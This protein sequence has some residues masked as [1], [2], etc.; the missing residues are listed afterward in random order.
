MSSASLCSCNAARRFDSLSAPMR[1]IATSDLLD[2]DSC[3]LVSCS[4]SSR[5][6]REG[7]RLSLFHRRHLAFLT[8]LLQV[9]PVSVLATYDA[10]NRGT[11]RQL[12]LTC[13]AGE[14]AATASAIGCSICPSGS[15]STAGS[16][17]CTSCDVSPSVCNL[18]VSNP[19]PICPTGWQV[20]LSG[21]LEPCSLSEQTALLLRAFENQLVFPCFNRLS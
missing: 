9:L 13:A 14:Y 19:V 20:P 12:A 1:A 8:L 5:Y 18:N 4:V 6:R 3:R 11:R 7:Q 10:S 2:D 15:W 16:T 21:K 17:S